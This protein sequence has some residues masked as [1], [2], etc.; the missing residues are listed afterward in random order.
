MVAGADIRIVGGSVVGYAC[1]TGGIICL[2]RMGCS[3]FVEVFSVRNVIGGQT[4]G[5]E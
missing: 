1:P 5:F 2:A 3:K 4:Q